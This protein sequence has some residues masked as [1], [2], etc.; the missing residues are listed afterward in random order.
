MRKIF[1][2]VFI[3]CVTVFALSPKSEAKFEDDIRG[4]V[5]NGIY[6]NKI[7]KIK[8]RF[9]DDWK[10]LSQK[11]IAEI[12]GFAQSASP[13]LKELTGGTMP[14]FY[15]ITKDGVANVNIVLNDVGEARPTDTVIKMGLKS[16]I[17]DIKKM[18]SEMGLK[19]SDY[20]VVHMKFLGQDCLGITGKAS[21]ERMAMYQKQVVFFAGDY[22][23]NISATSIGADITDEILEIFSRL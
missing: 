9:N 2:F 23:C 14:I 15:A 16:A 11:E 21:N 20:E 18:F 4:T 5:K 19:T 3:F 22:S 6:T 17:K 1:L 8:A 7:I 13:T 10:I 12:M